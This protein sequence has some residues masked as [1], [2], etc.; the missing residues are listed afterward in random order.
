MSPTLEMV[1]EQVNNLSEAER[2]ELMRAIARPASKRIGTNKS[3]LAKIKAFR[4]RYRGI[5]PTTEELIAEKRREVELE[6]R[7]W[8]S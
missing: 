4:G 1:L 3:R 2:T 8:R 6:E 5:M 7:K